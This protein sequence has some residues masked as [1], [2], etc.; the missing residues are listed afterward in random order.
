MQSFKKLQSINYNN[1]FSQ[2]AIKLSDPILKRIYRDNE[3]RN[4]E[5]RLYMKFKLKKKTI[6]RKNS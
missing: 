5:Y 6:H 3:D 2:T 1:E 4:R